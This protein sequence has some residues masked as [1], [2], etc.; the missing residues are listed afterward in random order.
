MT[1]CTDLG[2]SEEFAVWSILGYA[3]RNTQARRDLTEMRE[4][5]KFPLFA[6]TLWTDREDLDV[7]F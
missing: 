1:A 4:N 5:G 2:M 6:Q 3:T 7:V